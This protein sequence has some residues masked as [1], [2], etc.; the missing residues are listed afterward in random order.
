MGFLIEG[1]FVPDANAPGT[2]K[3]QLLIEE[4][5]I[6]PLYAYLQNGEPTG[7]DKE[8]RCIPLQITGEKCTNKDGTKYM[9]LRVAPDPHYRRKEVQL[10]AEALAAAFNGEILS[11]ALPL[12]CTDL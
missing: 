12:F 5:D 11:D 10:D 7:P 9:R 6:K 4:R 2:A 1:E 8:H 3:G